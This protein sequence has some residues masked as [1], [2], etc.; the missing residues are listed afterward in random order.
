ME[1]TKHVCE[2]CGHTFDSDAELKEHMLSIH[3]EEHEGKGQ[4]NNKRKDVA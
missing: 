4:E 2:A 1:R 3:G